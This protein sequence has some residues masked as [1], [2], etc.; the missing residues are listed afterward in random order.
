MLG[1]TLLALATA[2]ATL[3]PVD[4]C[5]GDAPFAQFRAELRDTVARRD[6]DALLKVVASDVYA[7]FGGYIGKSDFIQMWNLAKNPKDSAVWNELGE[8]L[9]LGCAV[10]GQA[11]VAPSFEK[12]IDDARDPFD[13]WIALPGAVLRKSPS[14]K[15]RVIARLKWHVL[16]LDR[17][18]ENETWLLV[19]LDDGR[20]GYVR[21]S[22]TRSV[23]GWR[24]AFEKREGRW[25]MTS[26]VAGD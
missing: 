25:L 16:T 18:L 9:D 3:P 12:Q 2:N 26:F 10:E 21:T 13:T 11:R 20:S 6:T 14:D 19:K 22:M 1:V 24:A 5:A 17:G 15:S 8:A 23:L 4:Q 7:G